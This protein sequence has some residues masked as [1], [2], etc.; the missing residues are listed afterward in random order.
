MSKNSYPAVTS[1]S[2]QTQKVQYYARQLLHLLGEKEQISNQL[3]DNAKQLPEFELLISFP[4]IGEISAT[5]FMSELGD[6]SRFTNHRKVH[7]FIGMDIRRYQAG[8]YTRRDYI[9]KRGNPKGRKILFPIV[10]VS[11]NSKILLSS[12]YKD[13]FITIK[14]VIH[15]LLLSDKISYV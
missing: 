1:N 7:A 15:I 12:L 8:K 13:C 9:N 3:I 5:L 10:R 11:L 2:V 14:N 4:G 6:L